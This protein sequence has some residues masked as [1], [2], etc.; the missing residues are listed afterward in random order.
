MADL[1]IAAGYRKSEWN[2]LS[3]IDASDPAANDWVAAI[4][5]FE[6]RI[7]R[8]FIDPIDTLISLE[9]GLARQNFGFVILAVDC[10]LIETIQGFREGVSNHSGKSERLFVNFLSQWPTFVTSIPVGDRPNDWA[11]TF[12][13]DCRCALH[14]TGATGIDFRVGVKGPAIILNKSL[15]EINRTEFHKELSSEFEKY[16]ADLAALPNATLRL[17]FRNKMNDLCR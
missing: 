16:L 3:L 5:I 2:Q 13:R 8:R 9:T 1:E 15:V 7:R 17:N 11:K 6:T 12:Y 14:H 10:L 4:S